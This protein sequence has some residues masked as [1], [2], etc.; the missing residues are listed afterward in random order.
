MVNSPSRGNINLS[1][2]SSMLGGQSLLLVELSL[3]WKPP[4][5]ETIVWLPSC[6]FP[7][8][9]TEIH[10][11]SPGVDPLLC[12]LHLFSGFIL[13]LRVP[14]LPEQLRTG[15]LGV[16]LRSDM[17]R[18]KIYILLSHATASTVGYRILGWKLF[19][20]KILK[21]LPTSRLVPL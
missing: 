15:C 17:L 18:K 6:A 11:T 5:Q 9:S 4:A 13:P 8:R 2:H 20:F 1:K 7:D 14:F 12:I 21:S 19:S 3:A 16:N 10:P